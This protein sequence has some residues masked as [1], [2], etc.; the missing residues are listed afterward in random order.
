MTSLDI[1][2]FIIKPGTK[3]DLRKLPPD[4]DL[5][6]TK[7]DGEERLEKDLKELEDLQYKFFA[8]GSKSLIIVLQGID[9]AGK[10][11]TIRKVISAFNPQGVYV[12][13]F[14]APEGQE[15]FHDYLWRVHEACPPLGNIAIFN[16]SHYEDVLVTRVHKIISED[17]VKKRLGH[18]NDFERML[19]D[20]GTVIIKFF[21]NI[22]KEEQL[23]RLK[24][25]LDDPSR[26]WKFSTEDIRE[27]ALWDDYI[28]VFN[29]TLTSTNT[30]V[31]PWWVVPSDNKW[32]RNLV[33]SEV[34]RKTFKD[35]RLA[36]P[37][38]EFDLEKARR[39]LSRNK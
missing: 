11:G 26:N 16:R 21:L 4:L 36:W 35:M 25:R 2:K 23:E 17:K 22:S 38:P 8:D 19:V 37:I 31:A 20:E 30:S 18:I 32:I 10:D 39:S 7:E 13:S 27:R 5:G 1:K 24:S 33:V 15:K 14:K 3:I 34:I 9:T 12:K 29:D 28:K 6:L